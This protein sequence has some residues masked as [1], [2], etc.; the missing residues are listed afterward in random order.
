M[1]MYE[2]EQNTEINMT[3]TLCLCFVIYF[4]SRA[5]WK[6]FYRRLQT[7]GKSFLFLFLPKDE[8]QDVFCLF[9]AIL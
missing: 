4:A 7:Q 9:S 2:N 6:P 5:I 8:I 3:N 1:R